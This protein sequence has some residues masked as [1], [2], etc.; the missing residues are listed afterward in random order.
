MRTLKR[1]HGRLIALTAAFCILI[2]VFCNVG[3]TLEKQE[4]IRYTTYHE[5]GSYTVTIITLNDEPETSPLGEV[6][7]K[8]GTKDDYYYSSS[9]RLLWKL[10]V[11]GI[12]S[13][14][15]R[16]ATATYA[17]YSYTIYDS[18]WSFDS[19]S[20]YCSGASA[21]ANGNFIY[22]GASTPASVRLTCSP[23]GVLS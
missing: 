2:N 11:F 5:D 21:I 8:S 1:A 22:Y 14:D 19:G 10:Q 20:A 6:Q 23:S 15:G 9:N 17:D 12:F 4:A 16:S 18:V 3:Y 7:Q 13:Y